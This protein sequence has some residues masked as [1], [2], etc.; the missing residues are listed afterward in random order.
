MQHR[1]LGAQSPSRTYSTASAAAAQ[2]PLLLAAKVL[3]WTGLSEQAGMQAGG[4]W[5]CMLLCQRCSMSGA[6][7]MPD[8]K[9]LSRAA[10]IRDPHLLEGGEGDADRWCSP[11]RP[12]AAGTVVGWS[13]DSQGC[14]SI[15]AAVA[16]SS[17]AYFSMGI[18]KSASAAACKSGLGQASWKSELPWLCQ[19]A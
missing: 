11:D 16:R 7:T 17:G 9:G 4:L 18:R 2:A 1:G 14:C 3:S 12:L 5:H 15:W 10:R 6:V 13:W 8:R 19:P